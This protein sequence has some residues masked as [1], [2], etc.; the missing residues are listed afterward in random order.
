MNVDNITFIKDN[1][2][3]SIQLLQ[4]QT[5]F[6]IKLENEDNSNSVFIPKIFSIQDIELDDIQ[7]LK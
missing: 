4:C 3:S 2:I 5:L 6:I 1:T 7:I